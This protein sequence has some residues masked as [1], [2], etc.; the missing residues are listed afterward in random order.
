MSLPS[1]DEFEAL[2]HLADEAREVFADRAHNVGRALE[3]DPSF[4]RGEIP[5]SG[6]VRYLFL[7]AAEVAASRCGLSFVTGAGGAC[8][9]VRIDG[10]RTVERWYRIRRAREGQNDDFVIESK[11]DAILQSEGDS[12]FKEERWV[13]AYTIDSNNQLESVFA[14]EILG[15]SDGSPGRLELGTVFPLGAGSSALP[16]GRGRFEPTNE[17]LDLDGDTEEE[18]LDDG[19]EG[20]EGNVA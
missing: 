6:M 7:E 9:L 4:Q 19:E 15:V 13:L 5:R 11:G 8:S 2:S 12:L 20:S 10:E 3:L 16:P 1:G 14:A 17:D 18:G